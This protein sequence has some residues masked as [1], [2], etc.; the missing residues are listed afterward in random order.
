MY[1]EDELGQ[2]FWTRVYERAE[3]EYGSV[4]IPMNTFNKIWIL[5]QKAAVYEYDKGAFVVDSHLK[6]MLEEDY[7]A[8]EMNRNSTEH[9]LGN[10]TKDDLDVITGLTA[11]VV[12]EVLIP[13]IEREVN[14]GKHFANLR[15]IYN[16]MI[17]AT[18]YKKRLNDSLLGQVY[19]N[20]KKVN[21]IAI[22]DKE[23]NQKIYAQYVEAF[24]KGVYDYIR[25]E[26]DES[27]QEI[28]PKKY[29]SGGASAKGL[30]DLALLSGEKNEK[31]R[32]SAIPKGMAKRVTA[33]IEGVFGEETTSSPVNLD[34]AALSERDSQLLHSSE[35][36][37]E[38]FLRTDFNAGNITE[39]IYR[40]SLNNT[41]LNLSRWTS[42]ENIHRLSPGI[43]VAN[44]NAIREKRWKDIVEAYRQEI[45][46]GTAGIRGKAALT[47]QELLKLKSDGPGAAILKGPNT[48]NDI[49]LLQKTAGVI[50]AMK[51]SGKKRVVIGYDSRI[52]GQAMAEMIARFFCWAINKRASI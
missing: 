18:W 3:A 21:G 7:L 25:E 23:A 31:V 8:L 22:E 2:E 24:K 20:Q 37:I 13:E 42:D 1:P 10:A 11:E 48:I 47:R 9:G 36:Q 15:Q 40:D 38:N 32:K 43:R 35:S 30:K 29:F 51:E 49:V 39:E 50:K 52:G 14:E 12:R 33:G 46:F 27:T 16:S 26:Y 19:V 34:L 6:V 41:Y 4:D 5:P 17:L 45:A 44:L 28:I